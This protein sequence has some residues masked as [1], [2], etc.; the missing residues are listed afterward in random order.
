MLK[1]SIRINSFANNILFNYTKLQTINKTFI[2]HINKNNFSN[3]LIGS[4]T[5]FNNNRKYISNKNKKQYTF[6]KNNKKIDF[7][8]SKYKYCFVVI[9]LG[10]YGIF[11]KILKKY[12]DMNIYISPHILVATRVISR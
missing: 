5:L 10:L 1:K 2:Q 6:I 7:Y 9:L 3:K 4:Q 8:L 11:F 12:G